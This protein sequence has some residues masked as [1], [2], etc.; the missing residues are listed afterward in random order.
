MMNTTRWTPY[1]KPTRK[2]HSSGFRIFEIGYIR[3]NNDVEEVVCT[4]A[5]SD[6]ICLDNLLKKDTARMVNKLDITP[7]GYIRLLCSKPCR[8]PDIVGSDAWLEEGEPLVSE[9]KEL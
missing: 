8:W 4:A 1:I 2:I 9:I 5:N 3:F 7:K 6:I